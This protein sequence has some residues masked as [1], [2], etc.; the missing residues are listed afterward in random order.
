MNKLILL[1]SLL[2]E[3]TEES[4]ILDPWDQISANFEAIEDSAEAIKYNLG[5]LPEEVKKY[6]IFTFVYKIGSEADSLLQ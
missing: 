5:Q 2:F 1:K 6:G 3:E 4:Q